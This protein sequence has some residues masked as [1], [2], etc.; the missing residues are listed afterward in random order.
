LYFKSLQ[1]SIDCQFI[2]LPIIS[3]GTTEVYFSPNGGVT[4]AIVSEIKAARN[5][6]LVQA[7]SFTSIP[8]AKALTEAHRQGV[9]VVAFLD[10]SQRKENY[11]AATFFN[12][13]IS[14][15]I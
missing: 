2:R 5:E 10:K 3:T 14:V 4:E 11:T 8:I 12:A 6:I 7:N 15:L 13:G 1:Y 9:N